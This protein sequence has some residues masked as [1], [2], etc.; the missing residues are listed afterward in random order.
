MKSN[1]LKKHNFLAFIKPI[2]TVYFALIIIAGVIVGFYGF[3]SNVAVS[4]G[5]QLVVDFSSANI[6]IENEA[7]FASASS[8]VREIVTDHGVKINSFQVLGQY[9]MQSFVITT[10]SMPAH[11]LQNIRLAINAEFNATE[12]Y[13]GLIADDNEIAIIGN[14][15]DLT[16]RTTNIDSFISTNEI[17]LTIST[18][19]F[20]LTIVVIYALF[21]LKL[22]GTLTILFGALLNIVMTLSFIS[23]ARVEINEYIFV[24]MAVVLVLSVLSSADFAFNM[25]ERMRDK[26]SE[27]VPLHDLANAVVGEN[28][29]KSFTVA[30]CS[31]VAIVILGIVCFGDVTY[32]ALMSIVSLAVM[33]ASHIFILPASYVF[34]ARNRQMYFAEKAKLNAKQ[35]DKLEIKQTAEK[36]ITKTEIN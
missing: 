6:D 26:G 33:F 12:T 32:V 31:L 2:L 22:A 11:I 25:K 16:R 35:S 5:V 19:L 28:L 10:K 17:L 7:D 3:R 24:I 20:A 9:G 29:K 15:Y 30:I 27:N 13:A 36:A 8:T 14:N 34:F 23:I 4:G 18:L 21:R 1:S